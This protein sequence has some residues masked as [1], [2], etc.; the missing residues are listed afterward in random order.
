MNEHKKLAIQAL[1]SVRGDD[2]YRARAAFRGL[3]AEEMGKQHGQSGKTRAEIL[4]GYEEHE[5]KINAALQ[6]LRSI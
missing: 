1:E 6:W 4:R 5:T 3:S 2:L